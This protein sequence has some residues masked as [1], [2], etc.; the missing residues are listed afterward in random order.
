MYASTICAGCTMFVGKEN[1]IDLPN[2]G[3]VYCI[4]FSTNA[5]VKGK[6]PHLIS[7]QLNC[8]EDWS[9]LRLNSKQW[10]EQ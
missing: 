5:H 4:N 9:R 6:S 8:N 1:D 3:L 7:H 10:N 2:S